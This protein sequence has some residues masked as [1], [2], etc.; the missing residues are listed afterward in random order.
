MPTDQDTLYSGKFCNRI[1]HPQ[2]TGKI[3]TLKSHTSAR[4][5]EVTL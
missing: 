3:Y 2:I 4:I 1:L 5:E